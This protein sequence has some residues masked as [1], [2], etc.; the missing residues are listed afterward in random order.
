MFGNLDTKYVV[1]ELVSTR[2]GGQSLGFIF[3]FIQL[4]VHP[5]T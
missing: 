3:L 1:K 2:K 4:V 5:F